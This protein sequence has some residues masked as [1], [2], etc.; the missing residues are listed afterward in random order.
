MTSAA[1]ARFMNQVISSVDYLKSAEAMTSLDTDTYWPKW[2]SPWWHMTLLWELDSVY[3]IPE[4]ALQRVVADLNGRYVH[5]FPFTEAEL[6]AGVDPISG[7]M[8]HCGLGTMYQ[9]L[10]AS[11]SNVDEQLPWIRKWI[12]QYQMNDGGWNCD[13]ANYVKAEHTSSMVSTLPMLESLLAIENRTE[14]E[15]QALDAGAAYL[16]QRRLFRSSKTGAVLNEDWLKLTF[17]RFYSYDILRGLSF[18]VKWA[19]QRSKPLP[20]AIDEAVELIKQKVVTQDDRTGVPIERQFYKSCDTRIKDASGKW[21]KSPSSTFPLL[22]W[23]GQAGH[24]SPS[25]THEWNN[26]LS[27]LKMMA[28]VQ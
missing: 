6:P 24:I 23:C 17:P 10:R 15:T 19:A 22:E 4:V 28:P 11:G 12:L 14:Q 18:C 8:C 7:V 20:P 27:I 9:I 1:H 25:L 26:V 21:T 13:E 5:F 16:L 2:N 3:L